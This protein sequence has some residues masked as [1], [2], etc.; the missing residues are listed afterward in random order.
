MAVI[1]SDQ[2]S[3]LRRTNTAMHLKAREC[4]TCICLGHDISH[5]VSDVAA[6]QVRLERLGDSRASEQG[7]SLPNK[8]VQRPLVRH[9][10]APLHR[11]PSPSARRRHTICKG[12][13]MY[14]TLSFSHIYC[15]CIQACT[16]TGTH[17]DIHIRTH[18][19]IPHINKNTHNS[20]IYI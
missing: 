7:L 11:P 16:R 8:V 9:N 2:I 17:T 3:T 10:T 5:G 6:Q 13:G 14:L 4:Y 15:T 19:H 20:H 1:K 12:S 18:P